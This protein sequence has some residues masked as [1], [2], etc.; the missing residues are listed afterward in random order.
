MRTNL[1]PASESV[2]TAFFYL[3]YICYFIKYCQYV[4]SMVYLVYESWYCKKTIIPE[5]AQS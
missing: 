5:W 3:K 4:P 1:V 2:N